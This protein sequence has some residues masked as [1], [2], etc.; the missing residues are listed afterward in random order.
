MVQISE[1]HRAKSIYGCARMID[2][3]ACLYTA[4]TVKKIIALA[5]NLQTRENEDGARL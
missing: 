2:N 3:G 1:Y 4:L 5:I